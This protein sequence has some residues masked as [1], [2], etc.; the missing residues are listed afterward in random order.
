MGRFRAQNDSFWR[1]KRAILRC[2]TAHFEK[3]KE[4]SSDF[5]RFFYQN[6]RFRLRRMK[7]N[8]YPFFRYEMF[9]KAPYIPIQDLIHIRKTRKDLK[10][11]LRRAKP[12]ELSFL[13]SNSFL[14]DTRNKL[15][16]IDL[17][18]YAASP[19]LPPFCLLFTSFLR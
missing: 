12:V 6:K 18:A 10:G 4:K 5:V 11:R 1:A 14:P 8:V 16:L 9:T 13:Q 19:L 7:E 17:W 15:F 3:R 2:K